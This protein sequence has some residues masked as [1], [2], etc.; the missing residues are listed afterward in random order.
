M[1]PL[2][3]LLIP[4]GPDPPGGFFCLYW[5]HAAIFWGDLKKNVFLAKGGPFQTPP[6]GLGVM[7]CHRGHGVATPPPF[8]FSPGFFLLTRSR[9]LRVRKC[10]LQPEER[11]CSQPIRALSGGPH[12]PADPPRVYLYICFT[13]NFSKTTER[14]Y[15][16]SQKARFLDQTLSSCQ[17]WCN[18]VQ[19]FGL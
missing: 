10:R 3:V 18:S 8:T 9:W 17:I 6:P 16:K 13:L 15:T 11:G 12:G 14:N 7:V 19:P 2:P 4:P 1:R 5:R